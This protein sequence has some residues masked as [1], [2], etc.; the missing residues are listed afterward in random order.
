MPGID[1]NRAGMPVERT[2]RECLGVIPSPPTPSPASGRGG[3][4]RESGKKRRD[5]TPGSITKGQKKA[6]WTM[7]RKNGMDVEMFRDWLMKEFGTGSTRSL[8]LD[9]AAQV[10]H[11]L[12]VFFGEEYEPYQGLTWGITK[13]QIR[14][15]KRLVVELGWVTST[16]SVIGKTG[17]DEKRLN[18]MIKKMF[19]PKSRIELLNKKEGTSLIIALEKIGKD[20]KSNE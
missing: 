12:K 17:I 19:P 9:E 6:I 2:A 20:G 14:Y 4:E 7:V 11:S 8:S 1:G 18:G 15:A 3:A 13:R 10:I 16:G 5:H